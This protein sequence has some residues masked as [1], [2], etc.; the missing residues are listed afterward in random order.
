MFPPIPR[1]CVWVCFFFL[2]FVFGD[3]GWSAWAETFHGPGGVKVNR[4]PNMD[5]PG[6]D[7]KWVRYRKLP[8]MRE[9]VFGG[10]LMFWIHLQ[11]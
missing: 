8:A 5:A 9:L 7:A 3:G 11:F 2:A 10:E 4:Y 6:N 1:I